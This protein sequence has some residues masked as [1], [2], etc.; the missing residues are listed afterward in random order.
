M[1][2]VSGSLMPQIFAYARQVLDA[3]G[4]TR[5]PMAITSLRMLLSVAW[6]AGPPLSAFLL[7]GIGFSGLFTATAVGFAAVLAVVVIWLADPPGSAPEPGCAPA[8]GSVSGSAAGS[9]RSRPAASRGRA[10]LLRARRWA[11][12]PRRW[13]LRSPG[14][15]TL[16]MLAFVLLQSAAA[17]GLLALPLFLSVDL[18]GRVK[19]AGVV[20]GLCA[21]LEI[22]LMLL[23]GALASRW[24]LRHLV[25]VGAGFGVAY[26]AVVA[27]TGSVWQVAAAQ[28]LN[29]SF[30]SAATGLGISYFQDLLPGYPGRATT[31][32][33]N[34][35]RISA[36]LAGP[37]FGVVLHVGY[38]KAYIVGAALC[39]AGLIMLAA[40]AREPRTRAAVGTG[41]DQCPSTGC[42]R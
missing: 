37:I 28:V 31:M 39:V 5:A 33:T 14:T 34:S 7:G 29:A 16:T 22:P 6:V 3:S 23:F 27:M 36:M 11:L 2:A 1:V 13:A 38:R 30:I 40:G 10:R 41:P 9:E 4:S 17:L 19:D 24:Q 42:G 21:A 26:Y 25:L 32:F 20:L 15:V 8:P 18:H 12:R 35:N